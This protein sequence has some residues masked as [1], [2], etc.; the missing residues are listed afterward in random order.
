MKT[1]L[2]TLACLGLVGCASDNLVFEFGFTTRTL[3]G[4][5][6]AT[7]TATYTPPDRGG[8]NPISK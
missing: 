3:D 7:G 1:I 6:S 2:L 8:K 5:H 4:L